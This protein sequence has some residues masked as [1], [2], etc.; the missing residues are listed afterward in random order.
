MSAAAAEM[1]GTMDGEAA[2]EIGAM[3]DI[4]DDPRAIAAAITALATLLAASLGW[5]IAHRRDIAAEA[6]REEAARREARRLRRERRQD[7]TTAIASEI[8]AHLVQL[9]KLDLDAH[10]EGVAARML[11]EPGFLPF[12]PRESHDDVFRALVTEI[13]LLEA[14]V[15]PL[16]TVY[17]SQLSAIAMLAEDMRSGGFR[18]M[19][20]NR[21]AALFR[22]FIAMKIEAAAQARRALS[23]IGDGWPELAEQGMRSETQARAPDGRG[24]GKD[25]G[26]SSAGARPAQAGGAGIGLSSSDPDPSGPKRE[27]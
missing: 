6:R 10:A 14:Q 12:V 22:D 26:V 16:V 9:Q 5:I 4:L 11:A 24:V 25:D 19:P 15:V 27:A 17:Y 23:E 3:L 2:M 18:A 13:H 21:R 20:P 7:V 8:Y 1:D